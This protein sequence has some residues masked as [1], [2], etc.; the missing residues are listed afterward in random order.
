MTPGCVFCALPAEPIIAANAH[1]FA[2]RDSAPAAPLHTLVLPRR[3]VADYFELDADEREAI[4]ALLGDCRR[5][6]LAHDPDVAGFNIAVNIG[7]AAGQTVLH[8]HVH[9]VPR[10]LGDGEAL[11]VSGPHK[12]LL[13]RLPPD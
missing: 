6:I 4:A 8:C 13:T 1:A 11:I 3:H 10:R 5:D 12:R 2:V 9:L 7:A